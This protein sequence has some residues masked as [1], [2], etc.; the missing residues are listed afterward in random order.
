MATLLLLN[1][2][3]TLLIIVYKNLF[4]VNISTGGVADGFGKFEIPQ[5]GMF[6]RNHSRPGFPL[7]INSPALDNSPFVMANGRWTTLFSPAV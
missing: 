3:I 2:A 7:E 6:E 5:S 1:V 4:S